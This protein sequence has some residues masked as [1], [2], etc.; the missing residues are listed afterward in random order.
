MK[1]VKSNIKVNTCSIFADFESFNHHFQTDICSLLDCNIL[2]ASDVIII[3][4]NTVSKN[5]FQ[6]SISVAI[7]ISKR[8]LDTQKD[9]RL[10]R[11]SFDQNEFSYYNHDVGFLSLMQKI[12]RAI[13]SSA[14]IDMLLSQARSQLLL[15]N[16]WRNKV[17]VLISEGHW[18][19]VSR[20]RYEV[21]EMGSQN[22]TV[23]IVAISENSDFT[24]MYEAIQ[25]PFYVF[26]IND[27]ARRS[28]ID[29]IVSQTL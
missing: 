29:I 4:D 14:D 5:I 3:Q 7:E 27:V 15:A 1:F 16:P 23:M 10:G 9:V 2:Y 18:S 20:V 25:D 6:Y 11:L 21:Q 28:L 24:Q 13:N 26:L 8:Y 22:V 12:S 17:V 19:N